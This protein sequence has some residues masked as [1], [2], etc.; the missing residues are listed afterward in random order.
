MPHSDS[1]KHWSELE[2]HP[3]WHEDPASV[4]RQHLSARIHRGESASAAEYITRYTSLS[5]AQSL[6]LVLQEITARDRCGVALDL[7]ELQRR[8]P[9]FAIEIQAQWDRRSESQRL[10]QTLAGTLADWEAHLDPPTRL[11]ELGRLPG[12]RLLRQIGEGAM[13][14]V[15]EAE[16][17]ALQRRV[18]I[19]LMQPR[20]AKNPQNRKRFLREA[21]AAAR[22]QHERI[23][24][25]YLAGEYHELLYIVMPL[26]RGAPLSRVLNGNP[27]PIDDSIRWVVQIAEGLSA[28]HREGL[29]HR[30]IKPDNLWQTESGGLKILDFG[31]CRLATDDSLATHHGTILG[32]PAYMSPEQA[33][34]R[35]V[36]HRA[37]LYSLGVV[38][39]QLLTGRRPFSGAN[40]VEMLA[41]V[42]S[43]P[44]LEIRELRPE[45]PS[46]LAQLSMQLL[47]K[48]PVNRVGSADELIDRLLELSPGC[49]DSGGRSGVGMRSTDA[50]QPVM[51]EPVSS[52]KRPGGR[53]GSTRVLSNVLNDSAVIQ[54]RPTA[55]IPAQSDRWLS[56][57]GVSRIAFFALAAVVAGGTGWW[58][59]TSQIDLPQSQPGSMR[60]GDRANSSALSGPERL[61]SKPTPSSASELE[62][63]SVA[64]A[65]SSATAAASGAPSTGADRLHGDQPGQTQANSPPQPAGSSVL[66]PGDLDA[67]FAGR[68]LRFDGKDST[69]LVNGLPQPFPLPVTI[70]AW[71]TP[72][73]ARGRGQHLC[74]L[75]DPG[76]GIGIGNGGSFG[77]GFFDGAIWH[78]LY[79]GIMRLGKRTHVAVMLKPGRLVLYL[80]GRPVTT[81]EVAIQQLTKLRPPLVIGQGTPSA[82]KGGGFAGVIEGLRISSS[83]RYIEPFSPTADWEPDE[84]TELLLRFDEQSGTVVHD[85][86]AHGRHGT[87]HGTIWVSPEDRVLPQ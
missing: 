57:M 17:L 55:A 56:G 64:A 26:L 13:G 7:A 32:T 22:L 70:E 85:V 80:D 82:P 39:Y 42:T 2:S 81:R 14:I 67:Q 4:L 27:L 79:G 35:E 12:Y 6:A 43:Q 10:D 74:L 16:D 52:V 15:V 48:D 87:A 45:I 59:W 18:A 47:A 20:L 76:G 53:A 41:Q 38:L 50:F 36:D 28:A 72:S 44:P 25:I 1:D 77:A 62:P 65:D 46:A 83:E 84:A 68:G 9:E 86:S 49:L 3:S 78:E 19:K 24:P 33:L 29:V 60:T 73:E 75:G 34:G 5:R 69:V 31:L 58:T 40:T 63:P 51:T 23:V 11:D 54:T 8:Y 66:G 61:M 37:D 30:D 71:V 21:L